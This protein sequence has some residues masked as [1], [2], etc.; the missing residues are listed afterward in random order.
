MLKPILTAALLF[1]VSAIPALAM[2]P[3]DKLVLFT[4]DQQEQDVGVFV[5]Q[6]EG[7]VTIE[8]SLDE[9]K[10]IYITRKAEEVSLETECYDYK[11]EGMSVLLTYAGQWVIGTAQFIFENGTVAILEAPLDSTQAPRIFLKNVQNI[12]V[13]N[14][15]CIEKVC[16]GGT[17]PYLDGSIIKDA[18]VVAVYSNDFAVLVVPA[19]GGSGTRMVFKKIIRSKA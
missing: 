6:K 5:S 16:A 11:C 14:S 1:C 10:H 15:R 18:T 17:T 19:G 4:N 13:S 12:G 2:T 9:T 3:T 7:V 8:V